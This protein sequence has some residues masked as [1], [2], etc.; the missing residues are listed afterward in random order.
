VKPKHLLQSLLPLALAAG[1]FS[2]QAAPADPE[3]IAA[4]GKTAEG[5]INAFQKGDAKAVAAFWLPDGDYV[6]QDGTV[7]KGRA[8]IQAAF[9]EL[10]AAHK[11]LKLGIESA[12]LNFPTPDTAVEDGNT[13]VIPADGGAPTIARYTNVHVKKDGKWLLASVRDAAYTPP[14]HFPQLQALEWLTG[15]WTDENAKGETGRALFEWTPDRNFLV[16]TQTVTLEDM[17]VSRVIEWIGWNPAAKQI[18]SHAFAS[19]GSI[20]HST[21][22]QDGQKWTIKTTGINPDGKKVTAT[23]QATRTGPDAV[24]WQSKERSLDGKEQPEI[25]ETKMT[26]EK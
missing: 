18:E 10:F 9:E 19:D 22:A 26:R 7:L 6:Q 5:F 23:S 25:P 24:A 8:A 21:W 3:Q 4:I 17:L 12:S 15:A 1:G 11:G 14:S 16:S 20:S 13:A 2:S